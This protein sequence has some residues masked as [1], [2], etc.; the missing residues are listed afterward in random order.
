MTGWKCESPGGGWSPWAAVPGSHCRK[1][2]GRGCHCRMLV[3]SAPLS[4]PG[5]GGLAPCAPPGPVQPAARPRDTAW[6]PGPGLAGVGLPVPRAMGLRPVPAPLSG[7]G[8]L[9]AARLPESCAES[10]G[11]CPALPLGLLFLHLAPSWLHCPLPGSGPSPGLASRPRGEHTRSAPG[12]SLA[13]S[14][15]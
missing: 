14:P 5:H 2:L 15:P 8:H 13:S 6:P 3:P 7:P 9:T 10:Q 4:P 1:A 12:P 11:R